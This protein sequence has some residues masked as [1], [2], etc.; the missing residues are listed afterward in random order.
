MTLGELVI[1][2]PRRRIA[3]V[4][5][6]ATN[7]EMLRRSS[8][9]GGSAAAQDYS[10]FAFCSSIK[11]DS[12]SDAGSGGSRILHA[13]FEA[14]GLEFVVRSGSRVLRGCEGK[15]APGRTFYVF[16]FRLICDRAAIRRF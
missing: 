2:S 5:V 8:V 4:S 12:T 16:G 7:R 13:E 15:G 10:I 9:L 14:W 1:S 11:F 6:A 3:T